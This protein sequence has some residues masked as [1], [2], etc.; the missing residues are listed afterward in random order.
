MFL[1][2][3]P[4]IKKTHT[5]QKKYMTNVKQI[6]PRKNNWSWHNNRNT[7]NIRK[8]QIDLMSSSTTET[9]TDE[10]V[11][12]EDEYEQ[13]I[14]SR[15]DEIDGIIY[16]T[17]NTLL[18]K[19]I[20]ILGDPICRL[21]SGTY[22]DVHLHHN[23][24]TKQ[25]VVIKSIFPD[26]WN[27]HEEMCKNEDCD[28][29]KC[30]DYVLTCDAIREISS[31]SILKDHPD[32]V[33]IIGVDPFSTPIKLVL[34][35]A[36]NSLWQSIKSGS[37]GGDNI[38]TRRIMYHIIRGMN[39]IHKNN[40]MHRDLKPQNILIMKNGNAVIA[41]FGMS[42]SH[43]CPWTEQTDT[44]YTMWWRA[45]EILLQQFIGE[46]LAKECI[47]D[48]SGKLYG[49][50]AEI[51]SIGMCLWDILAANI[52]EAKKYMRADN[53]ELQ[54][55]KIL[56][57]LDFDSNS[58]WKNGRKRAY[59]LFKKNSNYSK[60]DY[61]EIYFSK[62]DIRLKA[63]KRLNYNL[64]DDTWDLLSK[65]LFINPVNRISFEEALSHS[66]F[67]CI[68][69]D[70]DNE[71]PHENGLQTKTLQTKTDYY[72]N[73]EN[74]K[75]WQLLGSWLWNVKTSQ[76]LSNASYFLCLEILKRFLSKND[77]SLDNLQL[78]G[79]SA[80]GLASIYIGDMSTMNEFHESMVKNLYS[81]RLF[82]KMQK[83]IL[84]CINFNLNLLTYWNELIKFI[85]INY[86][87]K[88][89][90]KAKI[91]QDELSQILT[92]IELSCLKLNVEEVIYI[93]LKI[94]NGFEC[95]NDKNIQAL[96]YFCKLC[97]Q[98]INAYPMNST[99]CLNALK[100][101]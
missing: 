71:F 98:D 33:N 75:N 16:N 73:Y 92:V 15:Q 90:K 55:W 56:R 25:N 89:M 42:C 96:Q 13:I 97:K 57:A 27:K 83:C 76:K 91:D 18:I 10:F 23:V 95:A 32:I 38:N 30:N 45:P 2:I 31:L 77:I 87:K 36:S 44:V 51:W 47:K 40:I 79:I 74:S 85:E 7:T 48:N 67:D 54:L 9:H 17:K 63:E 39:W 28:N 94:Y 50:K 21:G 80:L 43:P 14:N 53:V 37:V 99:Y 24:Q 86:E 64:K 3:S 84:I 5:T 1:G 100:I 35:K 101:K 12:E 65:L 20:S 58:I 22:G 52:P 59:K 19:D 66:Y 46:K 60:E 88:Y 81:K 8:R 29:Y 41:D 49:H 4:I 34:E 82:T 78:T 93:A 62:N 70:I 72:M 61:N 6:I 26:E 68:R 69:D 11:Y